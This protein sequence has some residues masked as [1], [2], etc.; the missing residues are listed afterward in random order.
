[1]L[2]RQYPALVGK[3]T[4]I[5]AKGREARRTSHHSFATVHLAL[6]HV[7]E[8]AFPPCCG[9]L[10]CGPQFRLNRRSAQRSAHH[11]TVRMFQRGAR[12][13]TTI[14]EYQAI[15]KS[16]VFGHKP[17]TIAIRGKRPVGLIRR[18]FGEAR[19]VVRRFDDDFMHSIAASYVNTNRWRRRPFPSRCRRFIQGGILVGNYPDLPRGRTI[20][21]WSCGY[22]AMAPGVNCSLPAQNGRPR[23]GDVRLCDILAGTLRI[24]PGR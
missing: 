19:G 3:S 13:A 24:S 8:N 4:R 7:T 22:D 12:P 2:A 9:E 17:Q 18:Q 14:F 15:G 5:G 11:L 20:L 10:R 6:G 16:W 23:C 21:A 1:M